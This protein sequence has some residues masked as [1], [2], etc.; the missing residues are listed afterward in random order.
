MLPRFP[1]VKSCAEQLLLNDNGAQDA[2]DDD[3]TVPEHTGVDLA[4]GEAVRVTVK[5]AAVI[6]NKIARAP[7]Y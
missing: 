1:V 7:Q 2:Q 6:S 3:R 4:A 5:A